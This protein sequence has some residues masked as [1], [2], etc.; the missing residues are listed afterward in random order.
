MKITVFDQKYFTATDRLMLNLVAILAVS[1][2]VCILLNAV[3]F[4]Y[5]G[6][7][8][9]SW[10]KF[11]LGMLCCGCLFAM[12]IWFKMPAAIAF[13]LKS[14]AWYFAAFLGFLVML[15]G[16]QYTPFPAM[17]LFLTSLDHALH[18]HETALR[19]WTSLHPI[20]LS[21]LRLTYYSVPVQW[22]LMPLLLVLAHRREQIYFYLTASLVAYLLGVG[23]YYFFPTVGALS[24]P[25]G[26]LLDPAVNGGIIAFPSFHVLWSVIIVYTMR[27]TPT[28][29]F[30]PILTLNLMSVAATLCLGGEYAIDVLCGIFVGAVATYTASQLNRKQQSNHSPCR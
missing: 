5:H 4:R 25:M 28:L 7:F 15:D 26:H 3:T 12:S 27:H 24:V 17:D 11:G 10:S 18:L 29:F 30:A 9:L 6:Y 2:L 19:E 22:V 13:L 8:S 20:L 16:V 1:G 14:Y 23:I 21:M